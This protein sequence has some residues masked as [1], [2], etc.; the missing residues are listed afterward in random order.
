[1]APLAGQLDDY[2]LG[3]ELGS[4]DGEVAAYRAQKGGRQCVVKLI[5]GFRDPPPE[6]L[7]RL[8][9]ALARLAEVRSERVV[10]I[11]EAGIDEGLAGDVPWFA[12]SAIPGARPLREILRQR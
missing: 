1:M 4:H 6:Q 5:H 9:V 10:P 3:S 8:E 7:G 2:I 12:T 11:I